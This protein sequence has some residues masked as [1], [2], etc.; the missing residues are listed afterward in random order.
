MNDSVVFI[1]ELTTAV[2]R[3]KDLL[4][5]H[6]A[7]CGELLPHVYMGDVSRFAIRQHREGVGGASG[8]RA[9]LD[10]LF[11]ILERAATEGSEDVKELI[12]VSF[13]ENVAEEMAASTDLR[14]LLGP[15]LR[16]ELQL[17]VDAFGY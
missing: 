17:V 8:P 16:R 1:H 11:T 15:T 5:R 14:S 3:L 10:V 6:V 12:T 9:V 4:A 13:L 2:P 7:D